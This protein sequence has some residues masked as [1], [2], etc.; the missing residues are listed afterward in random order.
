MSVVIMYICHPKWKPKEITSSQETRFATYQIASFFF[1]GCCG[2][3][4]P[5]WPPQDWSLIL[6]LNFCSVRSSNSHPSLLLTQHQHHPIFSDHT[7]PQLSTPTRSMMTPGWGE[8]VCIEIYRWVYCVEMVQLK[9][10]FL[11][12]LFRFIEVVIHPHWCLC[13]IYLK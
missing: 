11:K 1:I 3:T 13:E 5:R 7:G 12:H 4:R 6:I 9:D 2:V 10:F 8:N